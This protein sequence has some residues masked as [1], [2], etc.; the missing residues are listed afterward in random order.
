MQHVAKI[1]SIPTRGAAAV[2]HER[3]TP[4]A[5][6]DRLAGARGLAARLLG[7]LAPLIPTVAAATRSAAGADQWVDAWARQIFATQLTEREVISGIERLGDASTGQPLGWPQF[8]SLCRPPHL[9]GRDL[10]ARVAAAPPALTRDLAH[11]P[12]W[13]SARDRAISKIRARRSSGA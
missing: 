12:A 2:S 1:L 9:L 6:G 4:T 3:G 11:D 10:A 7:Q 13:C 8:L 5:G